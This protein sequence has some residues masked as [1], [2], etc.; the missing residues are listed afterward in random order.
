MKKTI[1]IL[2]VAVL[3]AGSVFAGFSGSADLTA[4]FDI[5]AKKYGFIGQGTKVTVA[6]DVTTGEGAASG[7]GDIYAAIKGTFKLEVE[8]LK[9]QAK[10]ELKKEEVPFKLTASISEAGIYGSNWSVSII[11]DPKAPDY[12]KDVIDLDKDDKA[13]FNYAPAYNDGDAIGVTGKYDD[14][15][16][17]VAFTGVE[18][19]VNFGAT[20]ETKT[21]DL[22]GLTVKGG[23]SVSKAAG[24]GLFNAS[25]SAD[26]AYATDVVS[27]NVK[28]DLGLAIPTNEA[29]KFAV[30]ADVQLVAKYSDIALDAYYATK[31]SPKKD[32]GEPIENLLSAQV[33]APL[34]QFNVPVTVTAGV[35]DAINTTN[36]F[37]KVVTTVEQFEITVGGNWA[38]QP[39]TWGINGAVKYSLSDATSVTAKVG[40]TSAELLSASVVAESTGVINGATVTAGWDGAKDLLDKDASKE[41]YGKLFAKVAV[42]F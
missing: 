20:A 22:N 17:G 26:V 11:G 10:V 18:D 4:G 34:A 42:K 15:A 3:A 19:K 33:V 37:G 41:N 16:F 38:I 21:F 32:K 27:A 7:E 5:D 9:D 8:E 23:A 12:A 35:K 13:T 29:Q 1:A 39:K 6:F 36:L 30:G 14:Y 28:A 24:A 40:Y 2:L 31:A 25:A